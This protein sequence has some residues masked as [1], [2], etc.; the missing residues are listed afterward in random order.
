MTGGN[1]EGAPACENTLQKEH[2]ER[3]GGGVKFTP[4]CVNR[5]FS[6]RDR[7]VWCKINTGCLSKLHFSFELTCH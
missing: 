2:T 1:T 3:K 5:L 7:D 6:S 4:A